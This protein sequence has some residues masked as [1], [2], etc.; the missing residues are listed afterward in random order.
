MRMAD[1][2]GER[3]GGVGTGV[4]GQREQPFHMEDRVI[5]PSAKVPTYDLKPEMSAIEITDAVLAR[6]ENRGYGFVLINFANADMV[7]HTGVLEKAIIACETIDACLGRIV[8]KVLELG[9]ACI[10]TADHGK[11]EEMGSAASGKVI[12]EH[13]KNPVPVIFIH[14]SLK[15]ATI[16]MGTL[17]DVAPTILSLLDVPQPADM[18]GKNLLARL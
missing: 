18:A 5:I 2:A 10:I 17:A 4:S 16:P 14:P 3:V 1:G 9:G 8:P 15:P 7:G 12:T 13:T 6:I 11:V